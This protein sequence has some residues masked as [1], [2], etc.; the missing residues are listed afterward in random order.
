[1]FKKKLRKFVVFCQAD[2]DKLIAKTEY[3]REIFY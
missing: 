3:K 1:M 2:D